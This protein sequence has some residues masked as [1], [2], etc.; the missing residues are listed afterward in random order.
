MRPTSSDRP[1]K[2]LKTKITRS[3]N[4]LNVMNY[5]V[6]LSTNNFNNVFKVKDKGFMN[7]EWQFAM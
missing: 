2:V 1:E 6:Q 3:R 7:N 4:Q 5:W